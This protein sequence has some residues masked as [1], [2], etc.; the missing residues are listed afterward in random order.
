MPF[1]DDLVGAGIMVGIPN[2]LGRFLPGLSLVL[3][4]SMGLSLVSVAGAETYSSPPLYV[5]YWVFSPSKG[6]I[7][8]L[9]WSPGGEKLAIV[10]NHQPGL[11]SEIVILDRDG[12]VLWSTGDL[13]KPVDPA[14]GLSWSSGGKVATALLYSNL[15]VVDTVA[16]RVKRLPY[17]GVHGVAWSPEGELLAVALKHVV[18]L[19]KP[20]GEK[21]WETRAS[22]RESIKAVTWSPGGDKLAVITP[23]SIIVL[24][25]NGEILSRYSSGKELIESAK[26]GPRGELLAVL[27][28]YSGEKHVVVIGSNGG[29]KWSTRRGQVYDYAWSPAQQELLVAGVNLTLYNGVSG[30]RIWSISWARGVISTVQAYHVA[31]SP[32]GDQVAVVKNNELVIIDPGSGSV[33][34]SA[35]LGVKTYVQLVLWSKSNR[36]T[37]LTGGKRGKIIVMGPAKN[38][39]TIVV[40]NCPKSLLCTLVVSDGRIT[41]TYSGT[42]NGVLHLYATPGTYKLVFRIGLLPPSYKAIGVLTIAKTKNETITLRV[43]P[44]KTITVEAPIKKLVEKIL[45]EMG[46]IVVKA[47]P[48]TVIEIAK[49]PYK[50]RFK[51]TKSTETIYAVPGTYTAKYYPPGKSVPVKLGEI[52]V[53]KGKETTITIKPATTT[54]SKTT[55]PKTTTRTTGTAMATTK[56]GATPIQATKTTTTQPPTVQGTTTTREEGKGTNKTTIALAVLGLIIIVA[57]IAVAAKRR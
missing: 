5:V 7:N 55:P 36:L 27:Q 46:H 14:I 24:N 13:G 19:L 51:L 33:K 45:G 26:W 17:Q 29:V 41:K 11:S 8:T 40:K 47:S 56:P 39:A 22:P 30:K 21:V 38:Y 52:R 18:L 50:Y 23:H 44:G 32:R 6:F 1:P 25:K 48:G 16:K 4:V 49:G 12:R 15:V 34:W 43:E 28:S 57:I 54:T 3:I 35:E 9:A 31:W 37:I 2:S 20:S 53:E 10:V 42:K